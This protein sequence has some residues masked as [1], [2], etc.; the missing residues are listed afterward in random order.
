[1]HGYGVHAMKDRD[2]FIRLKI[3][4]I[5]KGVYTKANGDKYERVQCCD[6]C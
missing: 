4:D 6:M 1:M 2:L 3:G 5:T